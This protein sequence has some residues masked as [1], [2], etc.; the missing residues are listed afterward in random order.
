MDSWVSGKEQHAV[1]N[2]IVGG[3]YVLHEETAPDGYVVASSI[4]FTVMDDGLNQT[5]F[6]KDKQVTVKKLDSEAMEL[7]EQKCRS[8]LQKCL[9]VRMANRRLLIAG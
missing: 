5:V 2:L 9:S 7:S 3:T 8:S 4:E 1:K 6:M